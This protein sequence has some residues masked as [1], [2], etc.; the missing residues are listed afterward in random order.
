MSLVALYLATCLAF[1]AFLI[2]GSARDRVK[3][4][5]VSLFWPLAAVTALSRRRKAAR[6]HELVWRRH[7]GRLRSPAV[8]KSLTL[9][10]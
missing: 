6:D 3:L 10:G 4:V 9:G 1:A 8:T 5:L 2:E 7:W